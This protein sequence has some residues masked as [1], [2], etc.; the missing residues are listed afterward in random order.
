VGP[1]EGWQ[2]EERSERRCRTLLAGTTT[3]HMA[4]RARAGEVGEEASLMAGMTTI[5]HG[6]ARKGQRGRGG[7]S[8]SDCELS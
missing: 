1:A 3:E 6:R 5:A 8:H 4:G 2:P 7:G